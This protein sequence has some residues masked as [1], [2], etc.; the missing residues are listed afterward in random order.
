MISARSS[1]AKRRGGANAQPQ[2]LSKRTSE[3]EICKKRKRYGIII[4]C[5]KGNP[6]GAKTESP[7]GAMAS[8]LPTF[9]KLLAPPVTTMQTG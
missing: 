6:M 9:S 5:F 7:V 4:D 2:E 3:N 1:S 8:T